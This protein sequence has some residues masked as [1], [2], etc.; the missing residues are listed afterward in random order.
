MPLVLELKAGDKVI[1]NGAVV[2]LS[3]SH[4]KMIVHNQASILRGKEVISEEEAATPAARVYFALQNAYM[5]P[6]H[7]EG[8]LKQFTTYIDQYLQ[9][10]P[11]SAELVTR[12][13][14]EVDA[15]RLYKGLKEAQELVMHQHEVLQ[16]LEN[17][18]QQIADDQSPENG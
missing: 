13:K 10:C 9:S 6:E 15:G 17:H 12:I 18:L 8:Y 3:S 5:F 1:I 16:S 4:A 2:E 14:A 11:S 7:A